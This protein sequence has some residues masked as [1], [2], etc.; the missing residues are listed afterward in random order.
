MVVGQPGQEGPAPVQLLRSRAAVAREVSSSTIS[1]AWARASSPSPRRSRGPRG[2]PSGGTPSISP[3]SSSAPSRLISM[4]IQDSRIA[5]SMGGFDSSLIGCTLSRTPVMS[6]TTSNC[7]WMTRWIS[8]CCAGQLHRHRVDEEGH[9]VSDDLDHR[10]TDGRPPVVGVARGERVH[11]GPTL[12]TVVGEP[13]LRR[14]GGVQVDVGP[15]GEV[16]RGDVAV[17]GPDELPRP[18]RPGGR[19][20][21]C[22]PSRARWPE[23]AARTSSRSVAV[24]T[25]RLYDP[26]RGH[27]RRRAASRQDGGH[28]VGHRHPAVP[29]PHGRGGARDAR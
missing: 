11:V 15:L 21:P 14:Q 4:C 9:V 22:G 5:P 29:R 2:A 25:A 18:R 23:R 10:V 8:R 24:D 1:R 6:R 13:E 27:W 28:E 12:R 19:P 20:S 16:V 3:V 7:G 17:V 26:W